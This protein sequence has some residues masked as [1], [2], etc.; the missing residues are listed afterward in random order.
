MTEEDYLTRCVVDPMTKTFYLYSSEGNS[1]T[2]TCDTVEQFM[3][4]L[5]LTKY[6]LND[7]NCLAYTN[8]LL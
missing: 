4:V 6:L 2:L 3:D 8:P 7:S 5:D 1:Q